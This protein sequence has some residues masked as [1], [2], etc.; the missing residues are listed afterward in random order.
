MTVVVGVDDSD[1]SVTA[2]R[3]AARFASTLGGGLHVVFVSHIPATMLAVLA[4]VPSAA[5]DLVAAQREA[6][7][8][9]LRAELDELTVSVETVDLEGY[10]ADELVRYAEEAGADL[11]VVGSRG[12]GDLAS[13]VLGSTSHRVVNH[14][15]C[16]VLVVRSD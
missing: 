4:G 10:P 1:R 16:D 9:K 11:L 13:L 8:D 2:V 6:V 12:R 14:A 7:W 3:T 5:D 15:P